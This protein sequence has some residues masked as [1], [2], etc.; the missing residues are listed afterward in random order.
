MSKLIWF[1]CRVKYI[2]VLDE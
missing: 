1:L 2:C